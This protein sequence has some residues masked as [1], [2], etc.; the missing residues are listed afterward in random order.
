[1]RGTEGTL[2]MDTYTEAETIRNAAKDAISEG[3]SDMEMKSF[4]PW[5]SIL[6]SDQIKSFNL[7]LSLCSEQEADLLLTGRFIFSIVQDSYLR[8]SLITGVNND[9]D[10]C[11]I[12]KPLTLAASFGSV[13]IFRKLGSIIQEDQL[14][15]ADNNDN[16]A[17]HV[18]IL[19][20]NEGRKLRKFDK[21][22]SYFIIYNIL[23][24]NVSPP[25][26]EK[27]LMQSNKEG[28][29]PIEL[30]AFYG[31]IDMFMTIFS[32]NGIYRFPQT[33]HGMMTCVLY[34]I[35]DYEAWKPKG[36]RVL[37]S[38]LR[39]FQSSDSKDQLTYNS[40]LKPVVISWF[41]VKFCMNLPIIFLKFL[42]RLVLWLSISFVALSFEEPSDSKEGGPTDRCNGTMEKIHVN[43]FV[44]FNFSASIF[45]IIWELCILGWA[46]FQICQRAYSV[47]TLFLPE[48]MSDII[49]QR[50]LFWA[51]ALYA[52]IG[53]ISGTVGYSGITDNLVM[54]HNIIVAM[55]IFWTIYILQILPGLGI[56]VTCIIEMMIVTASFMPLFLLFFMSFS[57]NFRV[58]S[59]TIHY[60]SDYFSDIL[61]S[62]Y[63]TF[64]IMLNLLDPYDFVTDSPY[65]MYFL[66]TLF[67]LVVPI[68]LLNFLIG[69]MS[70]AVN[71]LMSSADIR[72]LQKRTQ[73]ALM[74]E[75]ET[76]FL[77]RR[78]FAW[79][80][81]YFFVCQNDRVYLRCLEVGSFSKEHT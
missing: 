41:K 22:N 55:C 16:N 65:P 45:C 77:L 7:V 66:H 69:L 49:F 20:L 26:R 79:R 70:N 68:L 17:V 25:G 3:T 11:N 71:V 58:T 44:W 48:L 60:C 8:T 35:T 12:Q 14:I 6:E 9:T 38:P 52:I 1:M 63:S 57:L 15:S 78:L 5:Y 21:M 30:A 62:V 28:L 73:I 10:R 42:F 19:A 80:A 56:Y 74:A 43:K 64:R 29:K 34:D 72:I 47:R 18:L 50:V 59:L 39:L 53:T 33:K 23:M 2:T 36:S 13:A 81:S 67:V 40:I 27:L 51:I 46:V 37:M 54:F 31:Q 24:R 75:N 32:E 4:L 76:S 61:N